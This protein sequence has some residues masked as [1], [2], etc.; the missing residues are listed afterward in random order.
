[1]PAGPKQVDILQ[2]TL[3]MM[4]LQV[5]RQGPADVGIAEATEDAA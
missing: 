4:I 2:G 1:M 5:L 3:N